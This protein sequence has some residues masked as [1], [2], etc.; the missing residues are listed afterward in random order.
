M[1][2]CKLIAGIDDATKCP[3]I[4]SI[5]IAGIA[6]DS[7]TVK[8]WKNLGVTDSK[9]LSKNTREELAPIIKKTAC[10]YVIEEIRP[11]MMADLTFNL[12]EWEMLTVLAIVGRLPEEVG[13]IYIDNWEVS[14]ARF[15]S[16]LDSLLNNPEVKEKG[17]QLDAAR[18]RCMNYVPEHQADEKYTVVGAASIL[19]KAA[20]DA[21]YD[22]LRQEYGDFGSGS[23]GDPK[24][25]RY[26]WEHRNCPPPIVRTTW[27]TYKHLRG[28]ERIEEDSIYRRIKEKRDA[29]VS[30]RAKKS[31]G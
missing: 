21:Q 19:A 27:V 17:F 12:N 25:R 2:S 22:A 23:P 14:Q 24:T 29:R 10:S 7:A 6:A 5:F 26:V 31:T 11:A 16:R 1:R 3:C 4:G 28:L 30:N 9:V 15:F 8:R 20:S 13:N 18:L